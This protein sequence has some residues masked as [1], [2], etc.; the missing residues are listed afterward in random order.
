MN[1][2]L[3]LYH[4]TKKVVIATIEQALG[5]VL[6]VTSSALPSDFN[7]PGVIICRANNIDG[8]DLMG[9]HHDN[10]LS[11]V[12]REDLTSLVV[13]DACPHS[14]GFALRSMLTR[15]GPMT[16]F[17]LTPEG[18]TEVI[19]KTAD[20]EDI[21]A[22]FMFDGLKMDLYLQSAAPTDPTALKVLQNSLTPVT[23]PQLTQ[24]NRNGKAYFFSTTDFTD[25][26]GP[27]PGWTGVKLGWLASGGNTI[28]S[29]VT[30]PGSGSQASSV[31]LPSSKRASTEEYLQSMANPQSMSLQ[32]KVSLAAGEMTLVEPLRNRTEIAFQPSGDIRV[33][34]SDD[35]SRADEAMLI[36]G[37]AIISYTISTR[38]SVWIKAVANSDIT[39]VQLG[40]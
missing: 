29:G 40:V 34:L 28:I 22:I 13:G 26:L 9:L 6:K 5:G 24:F 3:V 18:Q 31:D 38:I 1:K 14:L 17:A 8:R 33:S 35:P 23:A 32:Y 11:F 25:P 12:V 19:V 15:N 30:V 37:G 10:L 7:E 20:D 16:A 2:Q 4:T 21:F 36:P 39:I 27:L